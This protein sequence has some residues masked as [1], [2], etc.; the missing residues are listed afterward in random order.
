MTIRCSR[1]II[2]FRNRNISCNINCPYKVNILEI[3][4]FIV[5]QSSKVYRSIAIVI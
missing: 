4:I 2:P 5:L 1:Q 3:F